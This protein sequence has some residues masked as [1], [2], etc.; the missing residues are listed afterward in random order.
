MSGWTLLGGAAVGFALGALHF[1]GL[2]WTLARMPR[3]R[4]PGMWLAASTLVRLA[5]VAL[6][7][8]LLARLGLG[9]LAGALVGFIA[10]RFAATA[11]GGRA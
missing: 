5:L 2:W 6:V 1:V 8:S 9:W 7:L 11:L 10:A 3:A 4:R